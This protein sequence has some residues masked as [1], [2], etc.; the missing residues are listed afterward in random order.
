MSILNDRQHGPLTSKDVKVPSPFK[1]FINN[2]RFINL[3]LRFINLSGLTL[4]GF[5]VFIIL[6]SIIIGSTSIPS[7]T[8]VSFGTLVNR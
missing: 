8:I 6:I 1:L 3:F 4:L 5:K 7:V 2:F